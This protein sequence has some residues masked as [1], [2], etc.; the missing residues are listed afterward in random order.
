MKIVNL[1]IEIELKLKQYKFPFLFLFLFWFT[2]FLFFAI[3]ESFHS[4]GALLLLSL[5]IRSPAVTSDFSNFYSLVWPILMEVIF[6][7]FIMGEL[8]EKYNPVVTSR[9]IAKHKR[10]HA[11]IIG[12]HHG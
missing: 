9:I 3:T 2:G 10:K 8:L 12:Y 4:V 6:F 5:T 11:V 7:G 1:F